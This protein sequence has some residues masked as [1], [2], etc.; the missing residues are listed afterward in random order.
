MKETLNIALIFF[1][2]CK[3]EL[4]LGPLRADLL[5][6]HRLFSLGTTGKLI[7]E[8]EFVA[9]EGTEHPFEVGDTSSV[10]WPIGAT[11]R[12]VLC[13]LRVRLTCWYLLAITTSLCRDTRTT[14]QP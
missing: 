1:D 7:S 8:L 14:C 2:S 4:R 6:K 10:E 11:S 12:L 13:W 3:N 9:E 5:S